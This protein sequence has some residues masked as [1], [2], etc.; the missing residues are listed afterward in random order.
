MAL[1]QDVK[2]GRCDKHYSSIHSKCPYCG[3]KK[4]R[5]GK[6]AS[7]A[8][9]TRWQVIVGLV[10]LILIIVA[11]VVLLAM[12]LKDRD[13]EPGH[14]SKPVASASPTNGVSTVTANPSATPAAPTNTPK[15][16]PEPT[17]EPVVNSIVLNREDF[18]LSNPGDTF[19]MVATISPA[20]STAKIIWISEDTDVATVDENGLVTAVNHGSTKVSATAGG[21]TKEC[22]VR[23][24]GYAPANTGNGSASGD[25]KLSHSDV[26]I[27]SGTGETFMLKVNGAG[28][29]AT[30]T[31]ASDKS[32]VASVESNGRVK[33]V[34]PGTATITVTVKTADGKETKLD[35][36]VRVVS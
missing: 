23:V 26:T 36:T 18:T 28:D 2:C 31:Y 9:N 4:N 7:G 27:H 20:Q 22:I 29:G 14:T 6:T 32:G 5:D 12:S 3:A 17:P 30:V 33:A 24:S 15:P 34:S 25:L 16:T 11:V 21:V 35:C 8:N 1:F 19:Q 10:V 13:P